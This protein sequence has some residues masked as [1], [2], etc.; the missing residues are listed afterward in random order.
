MKIKRIEIENWDVECAVDDD[1]H[2]TIAA[3]HKDET[4]VVEINEDLAT[5]E[6]EYVVRLTTKAIED[7]DDR[8]DAA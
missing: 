6:N 7:E 2:L 4:K 5:N 8:A 1:G 3:D